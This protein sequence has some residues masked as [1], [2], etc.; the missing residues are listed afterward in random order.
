MSERG[1]L[2]LS[3]DGQ[4]VGQR[5]AGDDVG[6]EQVG[7]VERNGQESQAQGDERSLFGSESPRPSQPADGQVTLHRQSHQHENANTCFIF[8]FQ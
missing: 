7:E 3:V 8:G 4:S 1:V 6:P 2:A 5:W